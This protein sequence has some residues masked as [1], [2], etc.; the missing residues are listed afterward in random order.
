MSTIDLTDE[1]A[2]SVLAESCCMTKGQVR[3]A[4]L[5][6][7]PEENDVRNHLQKMVFRIADRA[8]KRALEDKRE[9]AKQSGRSSEQ[10]AQQH[11]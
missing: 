11:A 6:A 7:G 3:T 10:V 2:I 1:Q 9:P 8:K 4:I 5:A